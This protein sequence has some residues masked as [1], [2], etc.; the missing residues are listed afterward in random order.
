MEVVPKNAAERTYSVCVLLFALI[1]FSSFVSSIT[2]EMTHIRML[3]SRKLETQSKLR[4]YLR[5]RGISRKLISGVWH[6]LDQKDW[7]NRVTLRIKEQDVVALNIL[8]PA[9]RR[10]LRVLGRAPALKKHPFFSTYAANEP[11]AFYYLCDAALSELS[12]L[13]KQELFGSTS[14]VKEVQMVFVL[15]G[16]MDYWLPCSC[17]IDTHAGMEPDAASLY[18]ANKRSFSDLL[19]KLPSLVEEASLRVASSKVSK[20]TSRNEGHSTGQDRLSLTCRDRIYSGEWACE[21]ALWASDVEL[22]CPLIAA[23]IT[24]VLLVDPAAFHDV[25]MQFR[26]SSELV[27]NYARAFVKEVPPMV[28]CRWRLPVALN[29]PKSQE[30]AQMELVFPGYDTASASRSASR[31]TTTRSSW[32]R[33]FGVS[34]AH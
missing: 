16:V 21:A 15:E 2:S 27:A 28:G 6:F 19:R 13:P 1:T 32:L 34:N 7:K 5:E 11:N 33:A 29:I 25:I 14:V 8:P 31:S 9:M 17:G 3:N 12:L 23:E 30:M 20:A 24:E 26:L 22:S 18:V 4:K 10:D